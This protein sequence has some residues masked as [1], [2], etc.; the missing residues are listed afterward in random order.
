MV[1]TKKLQSIKTNEQNARATKVAVISGKGK[2]N[3]VENSMNDR[4]PQTTSK[5]SLETEFNSEQE[6]KKKKVAKR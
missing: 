4:R 3:S 5:Q 2:G 1:K 6:P